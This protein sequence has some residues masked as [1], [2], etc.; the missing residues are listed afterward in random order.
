MNQ[1]EFF[2]VANSRGIASNEEI[3]RFLKLHSYEKEYT[4]DDLIDLWRQQNYE[5]CDHTDG[6]CY[7][8]DRRFTSFEY[9]HDYEC[10]PY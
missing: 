6:L 10:F 8:Y 5:I 3:A 9:L 2:K 1:A 4:E 7:L